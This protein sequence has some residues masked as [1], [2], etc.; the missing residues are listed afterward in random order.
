MQ[1]NL[2]TLRGGMYLPAGIQDRAQTS[3][4]TSSNRGSPRFICCA[5]LISSSN[6]YL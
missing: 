4:I 1:R 2:K 5:R 3:R 6:L